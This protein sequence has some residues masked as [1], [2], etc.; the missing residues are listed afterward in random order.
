MKGQLSRVIFCKYSSGN[1]AEVFTQFES[2][3][4]SLVVKGAWLFDCLH[5]RDCWLPIQ[6]LVFSFA[7][8]YSSFFSSILIL[9]GVSIRPAKPHLLPG[10]PTA[11]EQVVQIWR[12]D[13]VTSSARTARGHLFLLLFPACKLAM[14][15]KVLGLYLSAAPP[16]A[17]PAFTERSH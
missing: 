6:Q 13:E 1:G 11:Q 5:G 15:L 16:R 2:S 14:S 7:N 8:R 12:R 4:L 3:H 17:R 10:S 9:L